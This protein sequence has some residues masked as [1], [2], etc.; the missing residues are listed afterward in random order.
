MFLRLEYQNSNSEVRT[1]EEEGRDLPGGGVPL[2][3]G[4]RCPRFV[5]QR[6]HFM[7]VAYLQAMLRYTAVYYFR[8]FFRWEIGQNTPGR[9]LSL[10]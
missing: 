7:L 2:P 10:L 8:L 5:Q 4:L 9:C 6:H 3:K 1:S